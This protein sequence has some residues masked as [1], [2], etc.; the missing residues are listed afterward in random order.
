MNLEQLKQEE[1]NLLNLL[2]ENR[3][4]QKELN[5]SGEIKK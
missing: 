1:E 4:K 5:R 3:S 2:S